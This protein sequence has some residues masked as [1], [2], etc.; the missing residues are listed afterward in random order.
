MIGARS[1]EQRAAGSHDEEVGRFGG[2]GGTGRKWA[3]AVKRG[4]MSRVPQEGPS[5]ERFVLPGIK[6]RLS[7]S[8]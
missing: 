3:A 2:F 6:S 7:G 8:Y 4:S 5:G 1:K